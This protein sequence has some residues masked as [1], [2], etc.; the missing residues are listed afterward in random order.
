MS[1]VVEFPARDAE[2]AEVAEMRVG[3][4]KV[5]DDSQAMQRIAKLAE[6]AADILDEVEISAQDRLSLLWHLSLIRELTVERKGG[7]T[8]LCEL[9]LTPLCS[10]PRFKKPTPAPRNASSSIHAKIGKG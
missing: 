10:L 1:E 7:I 4:L 5:R 2:T 6:R 8:P 9:P 3:W